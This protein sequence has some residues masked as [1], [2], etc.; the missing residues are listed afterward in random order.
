MFDLLLCLNLYVVFFISLYD[1]SVM[2]M[3]NVFNK[4]IC[5]LARCIFCLCRGKTYNSD[6]GKVKDVKKLQVEI[7]T[8]DR[9]GV[10]RER[11]RARRRQK[12]ERNEKE[13]EKANQDETR[14]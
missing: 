7:M 12:K 1:N 11:K 2:C 3:L 8:L 10:E 14:T 13:K 6:K 4:Y 5:K 9:K